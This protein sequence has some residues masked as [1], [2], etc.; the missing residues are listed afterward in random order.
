[1]KKVFSVLLIGFFLMSSVAFAQEKAPEKKP[2]AQPKKEEKAA[3]AEFPS[4]DI[5][6]TTE[7]LILIAELPGLSSKDITV[8]YIEGEKNY[9]EISGTKGDVDLKVKGD[10]I[11]T[12]R[13]VGKFVRKVDVPE[14]IVKDKITAE[15]KDSVLVITLPIL[16]YQVKTSIKIK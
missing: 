8:E 10:K 9:V 12:E 1:M 11:L 6:Q 13:H 2:E 7:S 4:V 3:K 14:R 15:F 16:K 5:V